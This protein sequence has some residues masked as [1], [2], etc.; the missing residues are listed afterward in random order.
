MVVG[1]LW[2]V[3]VV[4][5]TKEN[6][7]LLRYL[8]FDETSIKLPLQKPPL[9]PPLPPPLPQLTPQNT[10]TINTSTITFTDTNQTPSLNIKV[11]CEF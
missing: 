9:S 10:T 5:G 11:I 6:N 2:L 8:S 1:V 4:E 7:Q 3:V